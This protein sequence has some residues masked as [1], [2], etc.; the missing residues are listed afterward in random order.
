ML[1]NGKIPPE[2]LDGK[3]HTTDFLDM[4]QPYNNLS[5]QQQKKLEYISLYHTPLVRPETDLMSANVPKKVHPV[6]SRHK[7]TK[8]KGLY[9]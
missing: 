8:R 1:Y 5:P 6:V 2:G 4:I 7:V 3:P 9:L